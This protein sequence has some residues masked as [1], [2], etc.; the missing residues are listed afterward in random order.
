MLKAKLKLSKQNVAKAKTGRSESTSRNTMSEEKRKKQ[1][2]EQSKFN[3]PIY[4]KGEQIKNTDDIKKHLHLGA[5]LKEDMKSSNEIF[6]DRYLHLI[7]RV[8]P[9][10]PY[11][12][13]SFGDKM[14]FFR[15]VDKLKYDIIEEQKLLKERNL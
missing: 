13:Q 1:L 7:N 14:L 2:D 4:Y 12:A 10:L 15:R 5:N 8:K 6:D 11:Y 3:A 9:D